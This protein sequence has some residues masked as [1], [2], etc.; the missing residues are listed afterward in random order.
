MYNL[1]TV[2][3]TAEIQAIIVKITSYCYQWLV[4]VVYPLLLI[5][6]AHSHHKW[7]TKNPVEDPVDIT[8]IIMSEGFLRN[9]RQWTLRIYDLLYLYDCKILNLFKVIT[10]MGSTRLKDADYRLWRTFLIPS[11]HSFLIPKST[12]FLFLSFSK[13]LQIPGACSSLPNL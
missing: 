12:D 3:K 2:V 1:S 8:F 7:N 9:H 4:S 11:K 13:L 5:F 6:R 10:L